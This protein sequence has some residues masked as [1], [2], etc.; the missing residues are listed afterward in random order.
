MINIVLFVKK[1]KSLNQN[2]I[3]NETRILLIVAIYLLLALILKMKS[4][5]LEVEHGQLLGM[6]RNKVRIS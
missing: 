5:N 2:H 4:I 6:P 3:L 1:V